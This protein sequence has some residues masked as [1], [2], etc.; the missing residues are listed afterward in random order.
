MNTLKRLAPYLAA[1]FISF[2]LFQIVQNYQ[3]VKINDSR[4]REQING[5]AD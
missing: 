2:S 5:P 4:Y 3:I 1:S